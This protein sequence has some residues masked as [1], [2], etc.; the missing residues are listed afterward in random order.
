MARWRVLL[1]G[2]RFDLEELP[3]LF[4]DPVGRVIEDGDSFYLEASQFEGLENVAAAQRGAAVRRFSEAKELRK[5]CTSRT[6][7]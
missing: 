7:C 5:V 4:T 6:G 1:Q 3:K 2:E